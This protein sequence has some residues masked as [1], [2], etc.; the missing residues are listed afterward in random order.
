LEIEEAKR[1]ARAAPLT[2][3]GKRAVLVIITFVSTVTVARLL[4]PREYGLASMAA[5]LLAFAQLFRDFGMTNA[6]MRK[7]DISAEELT[8]LFW[9][10]VATTLGLA[11]IV[12]TISPLASQFYRE[13]V[14]MWVMLVSVVGF[15][16]SG[17]ALQHR[18]MITRDLRFG[19]LTRIDITSNV[20]GFLVTLTL[21]YVRRDV[22]AI[23]FGNLAQSLVGAVQCTLASGWLPGRPR[24]SKEFR[25]ILRFAANSSVYTVSV[26]LSNNAA[27][28]LIGHMLGSATLGQFNRAQALYQLPNTNLVSPV[29]QALMPLLVRLR[30]HPE[31]Y[32]LAYLSL[33]RRLCILL[34]PL[35]ITLCFAGVPLV[36]T[37]LGGRWLLAGQAF[38]ALS[39]N[40]AAIGFAATAGNLFI[41]QDRAAELRTLGL[42]ELVFRVGTIAACVPFGLVA[43]AIGFSLS[44]IAVSLVRVM[45]AGRKGPISTAD[46][47]GAM[48]PALLPAL[49]AGLACWGVSRLSLSNTL[50]ESAAIIAAGMVA[51]MIVGVANP[52]SRRALIEFAETFGLMRL[53]RRLLPVRS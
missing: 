50:I 32:R 52:P 3:L 36:V 21:A 26:F 11:L 42:V 41:T 34:F 51:A 13:P 2:L 28:I 24:R 31:E 27:P 9:F 46:Q 39:L 23:V 6:V 30:A 47:F 5:I 44:T 29:T 10:N 49:G 15:T 1:R 37:V 22:W 14:V 38:S 45:V 16:A 33:V 19:T 35:A 40:L 12:A 20:V 43:T 18:A 53:I 8:L 17:L 4:S 25:S 48:Y 7:G